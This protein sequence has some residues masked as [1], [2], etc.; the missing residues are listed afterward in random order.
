MLKVQKFKKTMICIKCEQTKFN[1]GIKVCKCGGN[2]MDLD[3]MK[4]VTD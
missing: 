2:F 4:W 3:K 1:N